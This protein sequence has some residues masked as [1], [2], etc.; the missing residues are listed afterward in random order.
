MTYRRVVGQCVS[1]IPSTPLAGSRLITLLDST[2]TTCSHHPPERRPRRSMRFPGS[3]LSTLFSACCSTSNYTSTNNDVIRH[4]RYSQPVLGL[5]SFPPV[6]LV[7]GSAPG[8]IAR[9]P[10]VRSG[11]SS[12]RNRVLYPSLRGGGSL[13]QVASHRQLH[14]QQLRHGV[15]LLASCPRGGSRLPLLG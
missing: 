5:A 2:A 1:L 12:Y 4:R 7:G 10:G 14:R 13:L 9:V 11:T 6:L 3:G 15:A 8:R